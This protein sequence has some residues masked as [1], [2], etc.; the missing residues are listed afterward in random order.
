M[1][2]AFERN[3]APIFGWGTAAQAANYL[4]Y[5]NHNASSFDPYV[6]RKPTA[7]EAVGIQAGELRTFDIPAE[8][9]R[10]EAAQRVTTKEH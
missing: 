1:E 4:A 9:A 8:I 5:L 3:A 6:L 7:A 2:W 10:I